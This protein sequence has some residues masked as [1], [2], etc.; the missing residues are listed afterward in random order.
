MTVTPADI[1]H[2]WSRVN[3]RGEAE[4]WPWTAATAGP[5][6]GHMR[7]SGTLRYAHR[8]AYELEHG[9]IPTGF[10]VCHVCDN[11]PC[12]NPRHLFAGTP[13]ENMRDRD[14]KG[15]AASGDRNGLRL[16]P[17]RVARGEKN[18][19]AKLT[20]DAVREI[21]KM[22]ADGQRFAEIAAVFGVHVVTA[23][24]A[25]SGHRWRHVR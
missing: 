21:R 4:C 10:Y 1:S 15:R 6:Y 8:I 20:E 7:V 22:R 25:A 2:F 3:K 11:P 18:H 14:A 23:Q 12:V 24:Q 5:G 17:E 19:K 9:E 16:H 13:A